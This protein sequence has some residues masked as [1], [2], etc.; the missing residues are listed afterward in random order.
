[1]LL[2]LLAGVLGAGCASQAVTTPPVELS[3]TLDRSTYRIGDAV[4]ATVALKNTS[5]D[6]LDLPQ[7][8]ARVLDFKYGQS[9]LYPRIHRAPVT[10]KDVVPR[11]RQVEPSGAVARRFVFTRL[12]EEEGK[13]VVLA[14]FKGGVIADG[15]LI[16]Q[17]IYAK[18]AAFEVT[19]EVGLERDRADGLIRKAQA[20]E[21]VKA[22][23]GGQGTQ[24]RAVLVPLGKSGLVTWVVM[25]RF[26]TP[27]GQEGRRVVQVD[28]YLG[29][30]RSLKAKQGSG[31][32]SAEPPRKEGPADNRA[33]VRR[34][35]GTSGRPAEDGPQSRG[36]RGNKG[37]G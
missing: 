23:L 33:P 1:V 14:T 7:F 29:K 5:P 9:G 8:D 19:E 21:I 2:S 11:P 4:V 3:V 31:R 17:S 15:E 16:P 22:Q 32:T 35:A 18:P 36:V 12:T 26:Q 24:F 6:M 34:A 30:V 10:S 13:Y 37:T 25:F 28:P 20:I 27:D